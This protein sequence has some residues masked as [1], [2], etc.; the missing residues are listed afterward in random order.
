MTSITQQ[1]QI[2]N[3]IIFRIFINMMNYKLYTRHTFQG[4]TPLAGKNISFFNELF[5]VSPKS[6]APSLIFFSN[7]ALP[8]RISFTR[9]Q[10]TLSDM[11]TSSRTIFFNL[12]VIRSY[13]KW[14]SANLA[15]F[16]KSF[17]KKRIIFANII[18]RAV[19][20][21]TFSGAIVSIK[22]KITR[23]LILTFFAKHDNHSIIFSQLLMDVKG[24]NSR[25]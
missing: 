16:S 12:K 1:N 25:G 24:V 8:R 7:P 5:K 21:H 11:F 3:S 17:D 13:I 9:H 6:F 14:F 2:R 20:S 18:S 22:R 15:V 10:V 23:K 4:F 19:F